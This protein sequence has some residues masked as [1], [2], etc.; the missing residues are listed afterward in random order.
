MANS[1]KP[2]FAE[3]YSKANEILVK[4]S[5]ISSFPFPPLDLVKEQS[6]IKCRTYKK[7]RQ[8]GVDISV[9]GS[10]SAVIFKFGGRQIIFYDDS[11]PMA[12]V[13]Y[14]ILHELGHEI[15]RHDFT[16]K[17]PET[18]H[19]YEIETNYFAAQLLMPE[20]L[21]REL[22]RR[23]VYINR[24]F[25]QSAFGVS[26]QAADKRIATLAKTNI[27]WRTRAEKEF[28]DIILLKF[29]NFLNAVCPIPKVYN[30]EDEYD[31]QCERNSWF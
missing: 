5:A 3:S 17:D 13:K 2:N 15:S 6:D 18:Y 20:Q 10:E 1:S 23:G 31:R 11:K 16:K 12:H 24:S 22:Q 30:F 8:Y 29:S 4:S 19:K 26:A 14:S 27:E 9:F 21:L 7:A 28:D 25:L